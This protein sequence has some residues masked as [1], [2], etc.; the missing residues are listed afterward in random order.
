[1]GEQEM[2]SRDEM[3]GDPRRDPRPFGLRRDP[4]CTGPRPRWD[5]D[6][7]HFVRDETETRR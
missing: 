3:A 6:V 2:S 1:M 4:R 7:E 5:R